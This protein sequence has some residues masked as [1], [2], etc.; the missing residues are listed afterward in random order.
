MV[1]RYTW[2]ALDTVPPIGGG[3]VSR[4]ID[5]AVQAA[6]ERLRDRGALPSR[7]EVYI[8]DDNLREPLTYYLEA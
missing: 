7:L 8:E 1:N 4:S 5:D 6:R 3:V 2:I